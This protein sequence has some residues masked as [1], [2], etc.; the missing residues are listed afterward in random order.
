MASSS[1]S[2]RHTKA[3]LMR[4][5]WV[6]GSTCVTRTFADNGAEAGQF[7]HGGGETSS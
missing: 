3:T 6:Y 1:A 4:I 5:L 2:L 7:D